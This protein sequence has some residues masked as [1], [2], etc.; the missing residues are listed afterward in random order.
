MMYVVSYSG[1]L[2]SFAAAHRLIHEWKIPL[3][4]IRLV[5]ADTLIEDEDLYRF[6]DE[7]S[8][9]LG[10]E[11]IRLADG[12]TPWEV[13]RDEKFQG[14]SRIAP[15]SKILKRKQIDK[16]LDEQTEPLTLVLGIDIEEEHRLTR[17]KVNNPNFPVIAP[18]CEKPYLGHQGRMDLLASYGIELPRLY[19]MG[20]PHNNCGGFCVRAG[21][22]QF[23]K[24]LRE[25]PDRF[26]HHE[27]EQ[28]KLVGLVPN[29]KHFLKKTVNGVSRYLSLKDFRVMVEKAEEDIPQFDFGGCGCFINDEEKTNV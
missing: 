11:L 13:F 15:C 18:L 1:G 29:V 22:S 6:L 3:D 8:K 9:A 23:D 14:N 28:E 10:L 2:G 25:M 24:L 27:A 7:T 26:A 19:K 21:L 20:F 5:F 12:R 4:Q 17:A 16:W